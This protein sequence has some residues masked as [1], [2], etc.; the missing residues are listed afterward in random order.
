MS[1]DSFPLLSIIYTAAAIY[2][3]YSLW[4]AR[5]KLFKEPLKPFQQNLAHQAAFY[6]S[7][8]PGVFIHECA[9]ALAII[10]LG[11]E[12][13]EFHYGIFYGYVVHRT[14]ANPWHNW[15]TA[16]AGTVGSLLFALTA[17]FIMIQFKALFWQYL[18][19]QIL[20]INLVYALVYY[21]LFTL[22]TGTGDWRTIY[23][24][25]LTPNSSKVTLLIHILILVVFWWLTKIEYFAMRKNRVS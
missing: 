2:T 25:S 9:H 6:L 8:P 19:R 24:F 3:A 22:F 17:W 10:L 11:E 20:S 7:I 18:A 16:I 23:D 12:V 5:K 13:K 21:P 14:F 4:Q 1:E 15:I